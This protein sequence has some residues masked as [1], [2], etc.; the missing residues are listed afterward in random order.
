M[1][2][3][4]LGIIKQVQIQRSPL[5]MGEATQRLYNPIPLLVVDALRL[6]SMGA[7]G[8]TADGGEIMDIHHVNHRQ[9]RN[10]GNANGLSFNFTSHYAKMRE[11]FGSHL[12][13]GIAA[14]NILIEYDQIMTQPEIGDRLII[15][16]ATTN[17]ITILYEV[18]DAPPCAPFACFAAKQTLEG[19]PMKEALQ[20]LDVGIRGFYMTL[21][22][23]QDAIVQAG[24]KV[25]IE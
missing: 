6:T 14:E 8:L 24:D 13:D 2:M 25:F 3:K 20:F 5:K 16:N 1:T 18:I 22:S 15:Q 7:F 17:D 23:E 19:Q 11:R 21:T 10:N 9:S 4:T 12:T